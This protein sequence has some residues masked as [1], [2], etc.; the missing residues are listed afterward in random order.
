MF[1]IFTAE[2]RL[3]HM[4]DEESCLGWIK[5]YKNDIAFVADL[6][7][8]VDCT[9]GSTTVDNNGSIVHFADCEIILDLQGAL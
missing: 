1:W 7:P 4:R 3:Y 8:P 2:G 9:C 5:S 6:T